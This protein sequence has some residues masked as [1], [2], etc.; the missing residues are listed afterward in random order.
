YISS[1]FKSQ[2]NNSPENSIHI[3]LAILRHVSKLRFVFMRQSCLYSKL[4]NMRKQEVK[5]VQKI[6]NDFNQ[7]QSQ[8]S[9]AQTTPAQGEGQAAVGNIRQHR[10][11]ANTLACLCTY[12]YNDKAM[13]KQNQ[14][15]GFFI[16]LDQRLGPLTSYSSLRELVR[17]V[18]AGIKKLRAL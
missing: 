14:Y 3:K 6:V 16:D 1:K 18:Q 9:V 15:S 2:S 10:S 5:E 8:Q 17:Y 11:M 7:K 12:V 13:I 4:Y